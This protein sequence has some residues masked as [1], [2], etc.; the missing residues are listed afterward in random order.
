[1]YPWKTRRKIGFN[2]VAY[3]AKEKTRDI[4]DQLDQV[5]PQLT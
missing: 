3:R 5:S 2:F 1:M 4:V